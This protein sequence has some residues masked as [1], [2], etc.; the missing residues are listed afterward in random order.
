MNFYNQIKLVN[1]F[2]MLF[3]VGIISP[4]NAIFVASGKIAGQI[5]DKETAEP[6]PGV[7]I[8]IEAQ[9]QFDKEVRLETAMG[10]ASDVDGYYVILNA[11]A[12]TYNVKAV[13]VG[14]KEMIKQKVRVNI[15]R[16]ITVDFKA[17]YGGIQS[18]LVNV[19]PK[20]VNRDKYGL[21]FKVDYTG[22]NQKF[23]GE[24]PWS[25]DSWIYRVFADTTENGYAWDG[26][27][28]DTTGL[29]PEELRYFRGWN[30]RGE[31]KRNYETI[32]RGGL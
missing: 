28:N 6:L 3:M 8:L 13:M 18:G 30:N 1:L 29:V 15:D 21:S 31:G 25:D 32:G 14:Y 4:F 22:V 23:Y 16:T 5:V 20:E 19:V 27:R 24:N 2:L 11:P 9:G 7:N 12:G 17:K 26:T 10:A